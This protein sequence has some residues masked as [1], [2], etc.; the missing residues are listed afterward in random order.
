MAQLNAHGASLA[1]RE[2][3]VEEE[4]R[5][6][7]VHLVMGGPDQLGEYPFSRNNSGRWIVVGRMGL[8]FRSYDQD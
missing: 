8:D 6:R 1:V 5:T 3:G 4:E 2:R 7:I